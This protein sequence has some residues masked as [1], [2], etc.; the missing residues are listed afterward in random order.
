[1]AVALYNP[2]KKGRGVNLPSREERY[3]LFQK[4]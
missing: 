4:T 3:H 2:L 1:M